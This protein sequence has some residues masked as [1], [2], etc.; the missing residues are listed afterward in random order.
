MYK[1]NAKWLLLGILIVITLAMITASLGKYAETV[2]TTITL[3]ITKPTYTIRFH[4]NNGG[5]DNYTTQSFTYGTSQALDVNTFANGSLNF[6]GWTTN[7]DG[8]GDSYEDEEVIATGLTQTNGDFVDLYAQW[9]A[10]DYWV[11]FV[12]GDEHFTGKTDQKYI[13]SGIAL[14]NQANIDRDFEVSVTVSNFEKEQNQDRDVIISHQCETGE[15]YQGFSFGYRDN[16]IKVQLKSSASNQN[17]YAWGQT[18]GTITFKREGAGA[19]RKMYVD[20]VEKIDMSD[21]AGTF[22]SP[23]LLFGANK[24]GGSL[25]L[26][27]FFKGDLSDMTIKLKYTYAE[28]QQLFSNL[29][30]PTHTHYVLDGWYTAPTGGTK[31]T[32]STPITS[33]NIVLYLR[34]ASSATVTF[35]ANGGTGTMNNQLYNSSQTQSLLIN[36]FNRS[37]YSFVGWNTSAN[38]SGTSYTN[39]E[40]TTF[41]ND[42]T[43]YAQW[44]PFHTGTDYFYANG[45][46]SFNKDNDHIINTGLY[47][48]SQANYSRNFEAYFELVEF[49]TNDAQAVLM[50]SKNETASPWPGFVVRKL[51]D[52]NMQIKADRANSNNAPQNTKNIQNVSVSTTQSI[53]IIRIGGELYYSIN[54]GTFESLLDFTGFESTAVS[55][56]PFSFGGFI[57]PNG[58]KGRPFNG[59][60][61]NMYVGF[62]DSS[63]TLADYQNGYTAPRNGGASASPSSAPA[64][65]S[66]LSAPKTLS[67]Q[68]QTKQLSGSALKPTTEEK[69]EEP[70][71]TN[72]EI[73]EEPTTT[74]EKT[75]EKTT[76][77]VEELTKEPMATTDKIVEEP[78]TKAEETT[79]EPTITIEEPTEEPAIIIEEPIE[80]STTKVEEVT[81]ELKITTEE[82]IE[83]STTKVEEVTE[84][85]TITTEEPTTKLDE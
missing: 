1:K 29:P 82:P 50:N 22:E 58:D 35:D 62:I 76:T 38:G 43:L 59:V 70:T 66:S 44:E 79:E 16:S 73:K 52:T 74:T 72:E 80:E 67:T 46:V 71:T 49:R 11:T 61:A 65:T 40:M 42:I 24:S 37:G 23:N 2:S 57:K 60:L 63:I 25:T 51:S 75:V 69:I 41:E 28:V 56:T 10:S 78:T 27:R 19:N 9:G 20:G 33:T 5:A 15:P 55:N 84:E 8:T 64:N 48:F 30:S 18:S 26:R 6:L 12:Y 13:D 47:M 39:M 32:S 45:S 83:E 3:N 34:W 85:S 54:N 21:F 36:S 68:L 17:T 81:E 4:P 14:F 31:V 77:K 53:R 7:P